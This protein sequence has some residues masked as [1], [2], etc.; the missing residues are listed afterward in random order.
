MSII[1]EIYPENEER[2]NAIGFALS[3]LAMGTL[4]GP[5][6][7]GVL[8]ELCGKTVPFLILSSLAVLGLGK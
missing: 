4:I 3:G 5:T 1:A 8:Y 2:G 7:G 6:Y